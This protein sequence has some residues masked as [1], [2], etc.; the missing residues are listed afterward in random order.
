MAF[1]PTYDWQV[2]PQGA[3]VPPGL[4]VR[5]HGSDGEGL[6]ARIPSVWVLRVSLPGAGGRY[7]GTVTRTDTV[8][9]VRREVA[10][11]LGEQEDRIEL[12]ATSLASGGR[13]A[14]VPVELSSGGLGNSGIQVSV[15]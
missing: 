13:E 6:E 2:V 5:P 10:G 7:S 8:V 1:R 12:L 15:E 3:A 11:L 14:V 9:G 4:E